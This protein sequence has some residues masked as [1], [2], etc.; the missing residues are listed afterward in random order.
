M[1]TT[2]LNILEHCK[3][4]ILFICNLITLNQCQWGFL[5]RDGI[6]HRILP[7]DH[8]VN[9]ISLLNQNVRKTQI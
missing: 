8:K 6:S 7:T 4:C 3:K 5:D 2:L 9:L 1:H